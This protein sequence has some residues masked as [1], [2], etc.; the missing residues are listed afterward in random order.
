MLEKIFIGFANTV[1]DPAIA[2]INQEGRLLFA[3]GLERS[4][5]NKRAW[6]ASPDSI[7]MIEL[8]IRKYGANKQVVAATSWSE[9][10]LRLG[11][12]VKKMLKEEERLI[13]FL[14]SKEEWSGR[15][16]ENRLF[17]QSMYR[18]P[19]NTQDLLINLEFRLLENGN[20]KPVKLTFNH[21][22]CHAATACYTS[23]FKEAICLV[24]DGLGESGSVACYHYKNEKLTLLTKSGRLNL[25]SIGLFYQAVCKA[26][27]FDPLSGEEWK[28]MGLAAYGKFSDRYYKLLRPMLSVKNNIFYRSNDYYN[29]LSKLFKLSEEFSS[30]KDAADLAFTAQMITEE[31]T[32]ELLKC[33][34]IKYG[35]D[36]LILTGGCALNSS[37]NGKI[38]LKSGFKNLHIPMAPGDDGNAIGAAMLAWQKYNPNKF[39]QITDTP[40]LGTE[41]SEEDLSRFTQHANISSY[42][43]SSNHELAD[44]VSDELKAGKITG[45]IQGKAEF[46]PRALGNRS[47]LADCR[48][49]NIKQRLNEQV[50]FRED[51]RPFAPAILHEEGSRYFLNYS[52]T[53]YMEKTLTFKNLTD[54][55]GVIHADKTGRVQ[56]VTEQ[57][58][59]LFYQLLKAYYLKTNVPVILNT[60]FNVMGRPVVHDMEDAF[61]VFMGSGMDVLVI[62]RT[63][64]KKTIRT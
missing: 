34:Y 36:N 38:L 12:L 62:G 1:H 11:W 55:P 32:C 48:D 15:Y 59:P 49:K 28:V 29:R 56:S 4:L 30:P 9:Q 13:P 47:I 61:G 27:L 60:S 57:N 10:S 5:K 33:I 6:N 35:I 7:G 51:F 64:F 26:C 43:C 2:I 40:Y 46:G 50:K 8:L 22:L 19:G 18:A 17:Q 24:Y 21:H 25:A 41:V 44:K 14:H 16:Y 3:E 31:L 63:I 23:P 20:T 58:N 52:Y 45:W 53:P 42:T 39:S 37:A 54:T